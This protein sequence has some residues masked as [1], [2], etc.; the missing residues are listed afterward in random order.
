MAKGDHLFVSRGLY[1]HHGIDCGDGTIIEYGGDPLTPWN[2]L[3]RR[4]SRDDFL[5]RAPAQVRHYQGATNDPETVV[6]RAESRL[7]ERD[8]SLWANNCEHFA[9]WC[10]ISRHASDQVTW[11][12]G[13]GL[14]C[15]GLLLVAGAATLATVTV[16]SMSEKGKKDRHESG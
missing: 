7:G 11:Y 13:L 8:Y 2:N 4:V 15:G 10:K 9:S 16:L 3:V 6:K 5:G 12:K 1:T 14:A